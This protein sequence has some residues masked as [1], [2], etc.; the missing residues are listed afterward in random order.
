[1]ILPLK[2]IFIYVGAILLAFIYCVGLDKLVFHEGGPLKLTPDNHFS[3][4]G[5]TNNLLFH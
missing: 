2:L 3:D 5:L 1:M 4:P